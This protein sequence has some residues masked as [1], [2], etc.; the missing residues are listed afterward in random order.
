VMFPFTIQ[1]PPLHRTSLSQW[2]KRFKQTVNTGSSLYSSNVSEE[3]VNHQ[4]T[5]LIGLGT[6]WWMYWS[7]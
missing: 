3:T 4:P 6:F 7:G 5:V 1:Q 2:T